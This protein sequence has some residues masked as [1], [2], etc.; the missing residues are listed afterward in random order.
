M[1]SR[2]RVWRR[3]LIGERMFKIYYGCTIHNIPDIEKRTFRN[4]GW[5][6]GI[7]GTTR[8]ACSG[9]CCGNPRRHF[10]KL[11]RQEIKHRDSW[12]EIK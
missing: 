8:V 5:H 2:E 6:L 4:L 12:P 11:T 9:A 10:G 7:L 3:T 1:I